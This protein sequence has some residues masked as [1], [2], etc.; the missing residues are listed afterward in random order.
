[1][2][3][4]KNFG[5][6][7]NW[8]NLS[9][10]RRLVTWSIVFWVVSV[11]VLS[12]TI[13]LVG[14]GRMV[15]ETS[16]RNTQMASVISRDINAK[17]SGISADIRAFTRYLEETGPYLP[18]Q[19]EAILH[20]RLVSPQRYP[21]AYLFDDRGDLLFGLSGA[22]EGFLSLTPEELV[23][24]SVTVVPD[25]V[26]S[27]YSR[28]AL[29]NT[30]SE[31]SF[32]GIQKT[33]VLY[34]SNPLNTQT[35]NGQVLVLEI[36]LS[37]IWQSIDLVGVGQ[38]GFAYLTS[39]NGIII[40]HP[41]QAY[42]GRQLASQ[43][44]P[45]LSGY[46]GSIEL[47]EPYLGKSV[48]AAYS[49]VGGQ[50]G[51]GVVIQQDL[52]EAYAMIA[53]TGLMT[54]GIWL[55]LAVLGTLSIMLLMRN[56]TKPIVELTG[57][58][59][60][61]AQTG[62]LSQTADVKSSDE[63]GQLGR[64]FNQMIGRIRQAETD[65]RQSY[66]SLE[67][68]VEER[69][70]DLSSANTALQQE[71]IQ[72]REIEAMLSKSEAKYRDLVE[73]ADTIVL[74]MDP[75]GKVI[76][77]NK[78]AQDFFGYA[79]EEIIGSSVI[80]TI[81][82]EFDSNGTDLKELIK[83]VTRNPEKYSNSE[84]ENICRNGQRVWVAWTNKGIYDKENRLS[85][86]LCIGIDRTEQKRTADLLTEQMARGAAEAERARLARDLHDAVSQTL[87]SASIIADVLPRIWERNS[88]E[89]MKRLVEVSQLTRGALAEM[90]TLL[91]ELRPVA[92]ENAEIN[93]LLKH[94]ADSV[95]GH[96]RIPVKLEIE[97]ACKFPVEVKIALYRIA[98]EAL[99]N[100]AKHSGASQANVRLIC[101]GNEVVLEVT[102]NGKGFDLE[103]ARPGSL[104][105]GI[106]RE[107]AGKIGASVDIDSSPGNG[108]R[109]TVIWKAV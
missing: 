2:G 11:S 102:D 90:R 39:R 21:A 38:S 106:M 32:I 109:V 101:G 19:S 12:L 97:G 100:I 16:Q 58:A 66:E 37:D 5:R 57:A 43:L 64:A 41:E 92:M 10:R 75:E 20:L 59:Q 88:G 74:E 73:N 78:F 40:A 50:L 30:I 94:L 87:F 108:T 53:Q 8:I 105:R 44:E 7:R 68:R 69:T 77:F 99:N 61:I 52:S 72:R 45:L 67:L 91:F 29:G 98:Q 55:A 83:D 42:V 22:V 18:A 47:F 71:I 34:L 14:Q 63:V 89:G 49:P 85:H 4:L 103:N 27:A 51:W 104:G 56:F 54:V 82:P 96:A 15:G 62:D 79:E 107:R 17:I 26:S 86:I 84:N 46:E 24:H 36:D 81:V 13:M 1:M 9:I 6:V 80:G 3:L 70:S 93:E 35:Q 95:T 60:K 48:L 28:I 76:F 25:E 23:G 65:L 31:V 33:P